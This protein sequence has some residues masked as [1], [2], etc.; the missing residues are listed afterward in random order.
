MNERSIN[1]TSRPPF[2]IRFCK[3]R[4]KSET[5]R[6]SLGRGF[7]CLHPMAYST[8]TYPTPGF[9]YLGVILPTYKNKYC[10]HCVPSTC[11]ITHPSLLDLSQHRPMPIPTQELPVKGPELELG[12][13][14]GCLP[15]PFFDQVLIQLMSPHL[16]LNPHSS[17]ISRRVDYVRFH[18]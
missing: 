6:V 15:I 17:M 4:H 13:L 14:K 2:Q 1:C 16:L 5:L 10:G 11:R 9:L 12:C 8:S 3:E 7:W 18:S